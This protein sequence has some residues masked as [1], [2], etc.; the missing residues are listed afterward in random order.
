MSSPRIHSGELENSVGDAERERL[1]EE[2]VAGVG[3]FLENGTDLAGKCTTD[4]PEPSNDTSS[5]ILISCENDS[6]PATS[7]RAVFEMDVDEALESR[8]WN[9][10]QC[11]WRQSGG[12]PSL[13]EAYQSIPVP[14]NKGWFCK[15]LAF[16][17]PGYCI[18]VGYMDAGNWSTNIAAGST[19]EYR[20]LFVI[21][22]S[23]LIAMLLQALSLKLGLV[24]GRDLAQACRDSYHK[25]VV[26]MLWVTAELAIIA[27]DLAE[28]IGTAVALK[29][30]F[31]VPLAAGVCVTAVDVLVVMWLQNKRFRVIEFMVM[32]LIAL[33]LGCFIAEL[34]MARPAAKPVFEG[35]LPS[36]IIT[37]D[38]NAL[39]LAI[40]ILGATVMPHNLYLH[41]SI[42]QTRTVPRTLRAVTEAIKYATIDS[43]CALALALFVN[44]AIMI[45]A[46]AA[47]YVSGHN[48]VALLEDA[49]QLL[50]P[51]LGSSAGSILFGVALLASG[52]NSTLTGTM[53]GQVV[54][55]GFLQMNIS[56]VWRRAVTRVF[57]IVPA[58]V[59]AVVAGP[60]GV[61]NLLVLSQVVLSFQ[62]PFAVVPLVMITSSR[63]KLGCFANTWLVTTLSSLIALVIIGLN[64]FLIIDVFSSA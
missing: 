23:N 37:K 44:A 2:S 35:L 45:V 54:M 56:P 19:Y 5:S 52:Q 13:S 26:Y 51:L 18:A 29:L 40:G 15:F 14:Q 17:G 30:L 1:V 3:V 34:V 43:S 48:D 16:L 8:A 62:L 24:S 7:T 58:A 49:Y 64:L 33:I 61:N 27:T 4:A 59:T 38:T 21:L 42:V 28:V 55:E 20:L 11:G 63:A 10:M 12:E 9:E 6:S 47:F 46:A 25:Y 22:L 32:L 36:A 57:A 39:Y 31:G 50:S 41:S 53:A 60:S